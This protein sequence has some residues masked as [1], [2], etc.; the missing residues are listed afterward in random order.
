LNRLTVEDV[1]RVN[2]HILAALT[3]FVEGTEKGIEAYLP[4]LI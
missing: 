1:P 3:N 4:N 2:S